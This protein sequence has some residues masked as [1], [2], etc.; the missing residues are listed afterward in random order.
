MNTGRF[1]FI[2]IVLI[3][4]FTVLGIIA[5]FAFFSQR[6]KASLGPYG[7]NISFTPSTGSN[8]ALNQMYVTTVTISPVTSTYKFATIEATIRS[9]TNIQIVDVIAPSALPNHQKKSIST[10]QAVLIDSS[11]AASSSLPSFVQYQVQYKAVAE[12]AASISVDTSVSKFSGTVPTTTFD[13][14]STSPSAAFSFSSSQTSTGQ[15]TVTSSITAGSDAAEEDKSNAVVEFVSNDLELTDDGAKT[16]VVGMRFNNIAVP[17]GATITSAIIEFTAEKS[18]SGATSVAFQAEAQ[19]NA[20]AFAATPHNISNRIK[21]ANSMAWNNIPAWTAGQKYQS[22]NVANI[23][24]ELV[25]RTGWTSGNSVVFVVSGSGQ[26]SADLINSGSGMEPKLS[27]TYNSGTTATATPAPVTSAPSP[28]GAPKQT[29]TIP[30]CISPDHAGTD[31]VLSWTATDTSQVQI[32]QA[33][34]FSNYVFSKAVTAGTLTTTA[35]NGF[36]FFT[37]ALTLNPNTQYYVRIKTASGYTALGNFTIPS[38]NGTPDGPQVSAPSCIAANY[39]GNEITFT[40]ND[41]NV[42]SL[43]ISGDKTFASYPSTKSVTAGNLTTTGPAGFAFLGSA[44]TMTPGYTY[45][46]RTYNGSYSAGTPF[47]VPTCGSL[48]PTAAPS[49]TPTIAPSATPVP[50]QAI[51]TPTCIS[52]NHSGTDIKL[53]WDA[54]DVSSVQISQAS[55]FS[56]FAFTKTVTTG[57]LTT[58][59]PDG[60]NFFTSALTLNP[61]TTYYARVKTAAGYT[62]LGNFSIPSCNGAPD[63]PTVSAPACIA[64]NYSGSEITFNWNDKNITSLQIS[65]DKTFASYPSTK[66]VT[67][68]NLTTTGPAG[69]AFL[70]SALNMTPGITYYV[71]TY[72]GTYSAG[73]P[74]IV[75]TCSSL[76]PT[77]TA[78][79]SPTVTPRVCITLTPPACSNGQLVQVTPRPGVPGCIEYICVPPTGSTCA[80]KSEGDANCDGKIN[81]ADFEA[82]RSEFYNGTGS[83]ADFNAD[84]HVTLAD[85]EIWRT[86]FYAH[87]N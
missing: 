7:A 79:I 25:N 71:R 36:N 42:I 1:K 37:T 67:A 72:N 58:T 56:N 65:G 83:T 26:R 39:T 57:S 82:W 73:T 4:V 62:S 74:F 64:S 20:P 29:I 43:Q 19:D 80:L 84:S 14:E 53:S 33:S 6:S 28:T 41:K 46:V 30:T 75:P 3:A 66:S 23:I 18:E 16:Q 40:W 52:S 13:L 15:T 47:I 9:T 11:S 78:S 77:V 10:Y 61:N 17:K 48:T 85:F 59:A 54:T 51:T 86:G 50:N 21:M 32:S 24:Q 35:P 5:Y 49:P 31:V 76:T 87:S 38:C 60:F 2:V 44:L 68:G 55:D 8:L 34:D 69:F 81:L 22:P 63:G 12:G 45:Y 27:I 70:G